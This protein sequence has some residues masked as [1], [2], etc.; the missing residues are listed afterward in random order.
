MNPATD[1]LRDI[2]LGR[3]P[4]LNRN[5]VL[6]GYELLF[7]A[8]GEDALTRESS[9]AVSSELVCS[10]F[11][12]LSLPDVLGR[13]R[14]FI[15]VNPHFLDNDAIELLPKHMVVF[16]L[17]AATLDD[18]SVLERCRELKAAG[19]NF[20][21]TNIRDAA[22]VQNGK[23]DFASYLKVNLKDLPP[24][25]I[26]SVASDLKTTRMCLIAGDVE[27]QTQ[28][29][30]CSLIGFELFQGYYFAKPSL[31]E[32]RS[33]DPSTLGVFKIIQL[34]AA[35]AETPELEEAFRKE[36]ALVIN[37]MRL[38]NSVGVGARSRVTS[39]RQAIATIGRR[40]LQRW[41][42]LLVLSRSGE[43]DVNRNPRMQ[44]AALR[45]RFMEL[46]AERLYPKEHSLPDLAFIAGLM[47]L[48]PGALGMKMTDIL[49]KIGLPDEVRLA[50]LSGDGHLGHVLKLTECYDANNVEEVQALLPQGLGV[51]LLGEILGQALSW[52]EQ[53]D[54]VQQ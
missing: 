23:A 49:D 29:E 28:L 15:N 16:A 45:A 5:E 43:P 12:E 40:Q 8:T 33:L 31:V 27:T 2:F 37:L 4:V 52:V 25:Q 48:I 34:L 51:G 9:S 6:I 47:S 32:G 13:V 19:Y 53:L 39:V 38:T 44:Y 22:S 42:Q 50:L 46:L 20:S 1:P 21:I 11:A 54:E 18:P 3:Q 36:P 30:F 41:L 26:Q 10:A 7:R 17:D 14:T 35:D 24:Q